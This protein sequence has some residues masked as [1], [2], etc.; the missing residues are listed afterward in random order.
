M[1]SLTARE[2]RLIA[3]L[4]LLLIIAAAWLLLFAP[5]IDGF[6][7]RSEQRAELAARIERNQRLVGA[8]PQLRRRVEAQRADRP[9]FLLVAPDRD[10][11]SD[12][13]RQSLQRSVERS[14][15]SLTAIGGGADGGRFVG[16]S[17]SATLT[18][19]QL[20]A[21]LGDLQNQQPA[22]VVGGVNVVADRAFQTRKLDVMDVKFDVVVPFSPT[23]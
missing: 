18:L 8:I 9:R 7:R 10:A 13:L 3:V 20:V 22:L 12:L 21:L 16:A 23:A 14:G 17:V 11:A 2:Q 1:T 15:G 6:V 4:I 5:V 19:D